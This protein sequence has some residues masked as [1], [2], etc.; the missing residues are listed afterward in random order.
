M[1]QGNDWIM[2]REYT[3]V[4]PYALVFYGWGVRS[5]LPH[6]GSQRLHGMATAHDEAPDGSES[7]LGAAGFDVTQIIP[8]PLRQGQI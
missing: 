8:T 6:E 4:D 1:I 2:G 7:L 3:L 5:G